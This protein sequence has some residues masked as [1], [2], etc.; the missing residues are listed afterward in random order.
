MK[1]DPDYTMLFVR[2]QKPESFQKIGLIFNS[3][4]YLK[5]LFILSIVENL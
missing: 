2:R 3:V 5:K 4:L 1:Y